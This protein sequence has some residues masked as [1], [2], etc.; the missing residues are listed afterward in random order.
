MKIDFQKETR[1][2]GIAISPGIASTRICLF[3]EKSTLIRNFTIIYDMKNTGG[4][5]DEHETH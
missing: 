5:N 3:N 1:L 4:Y 2:Q